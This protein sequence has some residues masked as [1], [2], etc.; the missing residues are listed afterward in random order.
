[1]SERTLLTGAL[2]P[3][4]V[5]ADLLIEGATIREVLAPGTIS[6]PAAQRLPVDGRLLTPG[7]TDPHLHPD[8]A[9]GL[10]SDSTSAATLAE[11]I[12][13]VRARKPYETAA[14]VQQR[15]EQL[16]R[17]CLRFGTTRVRAHAEIDPYLGLRSVEG[18]LAA[19]EAL[20]GLVHVEVVAF[21]QE[22]ILREPGTIELMR[23]ALVMGCDVV[24]AIT[25]QDPDAREHLALAASLASELGLPL[26]VHADFGIPLERSALSTLVDVT[27]RY[28]LEGRVTAGHCTTLARLGEPDFTE[29]VSRLRDAQITV[30]A[31]P[32]TDLYMD[33]VI[34]PL[35]ELRAAGVPGFL[36]TNNVRNAFTPVGRPSLPSGAA[37]YALARRQGARAALNALAEGLWGAAAV[38]GVEAAILSGMPADLCIWPCTEAWQIIACEAE[39]D[40]VF[41]E[42]R[43]VAGRKEN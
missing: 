25:Y 23:E 26:D 12:A 5:R 4:G 16:L 7:L 20:R 10:D 32:R 37:V 42:G 38:C 28:G 35:E 17:W 13:R 8:K 9:F 40:A 34:A 39:P 1:M 41:V 3:N 19:R 22:G 29:I 24:G 33:G 30:V 36:G 43:L 18:V 11:A 6:V 15:T 14:A 27:H 31:L 21:P 2:L